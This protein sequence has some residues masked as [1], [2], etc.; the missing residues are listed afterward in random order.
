V[1][2]VVATAPGGRSEDPDPLD[3]ADVGG[4]RV[5]VVL[6]RMLSSRLIR[7]G[8][9]VVAG[10]LGGYAVARQWGQVRAELAQ[11]G[12]LTVVAALVAVLAGLIA[13]MQV[14][15]VLLSALGSPLSA[16]TAS[17]IFFLGQLGKY[18]PGSMWPVLVQMEMAQAARVPRSRSATAAVLTLVTSLC[19]GLLAALATL[20]FLPFL[21]TG[22][23]PPTEPSL[24]TSATADFR[25]A[26]LAVPVLLAL[27][28]PR[29][30]NAAAGRLLRMTGRPPLERPLS[31]RAVAVAMVWALLS[32]VLFGAQVWLLAMRLGAPPGRGLLVAVGGFALAWSAGFLVVLAPAGAGVREVL[33]VAT[34]AAVLSVGAATTVALVSRVL[35]TVGDLVL[36]G[37]AGWF[38]GKR[39]GPL[40]PDTS[41]GPQG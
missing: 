41:Q 10:G 38:A 35:M 4:R 28:H 14:W 30:V 25:W 8:F 17:R 29:V 5:V 19:A 37:V 16:R 15:R 18:I 1:P 34:L 24:P 2:I 3:R 27:L 21:P 40:T 9:V 26:F 36:A 33:L 7:V 31:A 39:P 12:W 13:T 6:R 32:W 23:Y 22:P 11:L 20:P